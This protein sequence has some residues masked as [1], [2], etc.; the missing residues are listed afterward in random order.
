MHSGLSKKKNRTVSIKKYRGRL[1]LNLGIILFAVVLIYL[2]VTVISYFSRDNI[3]VYE[4]RRG[5]IVR[6]NTYTGLVIREETAVTAEDEG[7]V[8]YYQNG[9]SKVRTGTNVYALSKEPVNT[10]SENSDTADGISL[11][12]DLQTGIV[13]QI[14]SYNEN[15]NANDFSK[16]YSLKNTIN[17]SLQD[18]YSLTRTQQLDAVIKESGIK[19]QSFKGRNPCIY[20]RRI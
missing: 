10:Y 19:V 4:V 3:S 8:S 1:D 11:N 14:Q 20:S 13:L 5:S 18:T 9:N 15:Y 16:V 6:D 17:T 7:Y 12:P 2:L